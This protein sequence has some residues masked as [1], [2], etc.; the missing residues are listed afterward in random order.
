MTRS[1]QGTGGPSA[2]AEVPEGVLVQHVADEMVLL[3]VESGVYYGLEPIGTRML[4]L[5]C[6]LPDADTV[7][8][9]MVEEYDTTAE[10]LHRDL[11]RLLDDLAEKGLVRLRG[12]PQE[13]EAS[14]TAEGNER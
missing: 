3:H 9:Q 11:Q 6:E 5:A 1:E 4:D 2:Y 10:V 7:V 12:R 14:S 8:D 13:P